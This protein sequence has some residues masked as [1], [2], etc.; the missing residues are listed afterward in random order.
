MCAPADGDL[1]LRGGAEAGMAELALDDVQ[2]HALARE[3]ER[4]CVAQ[5]VRREAACDA[6][7]GREAPELAAKPRRP[8]TAARGSGRR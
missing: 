7:L 2:R 6:R 4:V 8:T 1:S 5:L 3:L